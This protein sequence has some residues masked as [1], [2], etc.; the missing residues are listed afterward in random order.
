MPPTY[1]TNKVLEKQATGENDNTWG[2]RLNT[3][4]DNIDSCF[5]RQAVSVAGSTDVTLTDAQARALIQESTGVLT[6]NISVIVPTRAAVY[7]WYNNTTG[8]YSLTVK[9]ASG[10][11]VVVAQGS[12]LVLICDGTNV[13]AQTTDFPQ[14]V[15]FS[16]FLSPT[17]ISSNQNDYSP[18]G[19]STASVLRLDTD[20]ARDIT[21]LAGGRA[22]RVLTLLYIGT[23]SVTLK[24]QSS[25]SSAANRFL[26]PADVVLTPNTVVELIYDAVSA[27]WRIKAAYV[28]GIPIGAG[29]DFWGTTAPTGWA[30]PYGQNISRTTYALAY[31]VLGTTY[32]VGDGST[33]FTLPDKR[34]RGSVAKDDMGGSAASRVTTAGSGIDGATLG[35]TGGAETVTLTTTTMPTHSHSVTDPTHAHGAYIWDNHSNVTGPPGGV[36]G[37]SISTYNPTLAAATG[38]SIAN[39][40]SG[41]AHNNMGPGIVCN[42]IIYLGA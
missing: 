15:S 14:D 16:G 20:A 8:S 9:T 12:R 10:T 3:V 24:S 21:G 41:A 31:A 7:V 30:F 23:T 13:V 33:T 29:V 27:R 19:L 11:G 37:G 5:G 42:Y 38:I 1:T 40:G 17:Q 2:D 32:G 25:S 26:I 39:A 35:A 28:G 18:S 4:L 6:G 22:G 36:A 34:G